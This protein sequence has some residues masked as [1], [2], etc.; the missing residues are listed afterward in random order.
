[1]L[2]GLKEEKALNYV[3]INKKQKSFFKQIKNTKAAV[4]KDQDQDFS[5]EMTK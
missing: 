5:K 2:C 1:V 3:I 4:G